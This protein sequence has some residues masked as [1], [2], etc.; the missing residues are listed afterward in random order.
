MAKYLIALGL[1]RRNTVRAGNTIKVLDG[2]VY[3]GALWR[4]AKVR[5]IAD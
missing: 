3:G 4:R 5:R 1:V 2:V